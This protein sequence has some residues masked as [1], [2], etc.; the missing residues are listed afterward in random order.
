MIIIVQKVTGL[1]YGSPLLFITIQIA[2]VSLV[3][4][5]FY[6]DTLHANWLYN[7]LLWVAEIITGSAK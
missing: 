3:F 7:T 1:I 2:C 5:K 4:Y 6:T